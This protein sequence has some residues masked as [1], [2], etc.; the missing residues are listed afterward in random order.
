MPSYLPESLCEFIDPTSTYA[1]LRNLT[2]AAE[3]GMIEL[4]AIASY[5]RAVEKGEK[6]RFSRTVPIPLIMIE[7]IQRRKHI[8]PRKV[9]YQGLEEGLW[10]WPEVEAWENNQAVISEAHRKAPPRK[11]VY[12]TRGRKVAPR[13][14]RTGG[15]FVPK[16]SLDAVC[17]FKICDGAKACLSVL[18]SL[19]GKETTLT[20]YTLSV[21]SLLGR[22]TRTV[23]NHFIALEEAGLILRTPGSKP[24]TVRI[25]ITETCRPE[26]Y[27]EPVDVKAYKLARRS[28]N[29]ALQM[30]AFTAASAAMQAFPAE[31]QMEEGRKE[32]SGFNPESIFFLLEAPATAQTARRSQGA[33]THSNL[34]RGE[35]AGMLERLSSPNSK[36]RHGTAS[37]TAKGA[38]L[39]PAFGGHTALERH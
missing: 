7:T 31:F 3:V 25:T 38:S 27:K 18:M 24:N 16:M 13:L 12:L 4:S 33:T 10:G 34:V 26:P 39:S 19:A 37:P 15:M 21:A 22:T 17:S 5:A 11:G 9:V 1:S 36:W 2:A 20:T 28:G 32:I 35:R 23:R 30:L 14:P 6:I 8:E 29:P